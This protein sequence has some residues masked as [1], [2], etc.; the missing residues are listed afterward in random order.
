M[1]GHAGDALRLGPRVGWPGSRCAERSAVFAVAVLRF[2]ADGPV[3]RGLARLERRN[4]D[5][6]RLQ[7]AR[8][9]KLSAS[10]SVKSRPSMPPTNTP[11][12]P[13]STASTAARRF[14]TLPCPNGTSVMTTASAARASRVASDAAASSIGAK[15]ANS[16]NSTR[17][18]VATVSSASPVLSAPALTSQPASTSRRSRGAAAPEPPPRTPVPCQRARRLRR[19]APGPH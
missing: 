14:A 15:G 18:A 19:G 4:L 1:R 17:S 3:E 12:T 5:G 2:G 6:A 11:A 8:R 16:G 10:P 13:D 9:H 7:V